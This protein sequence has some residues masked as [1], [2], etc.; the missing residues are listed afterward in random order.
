MAFG[1][2]SYLRRRSG[3]TLTLPIRNY[4]HALFPP[5]SPYWRAAYLCSTA[6]FQSISRGFAPSIPASAARSTGDAGQSQL[7][8]Y[9][10]LTFASHLY[11]N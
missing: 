9:T 1:R 8:T 5:A 3:H 2:I 6:D 11:I 10:M 7:Y 4:Y